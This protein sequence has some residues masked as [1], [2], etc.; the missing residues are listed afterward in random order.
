MTRPRADNRSVQGPRF[1]CPDLK[2]GAN[3]LRDEESRHATQV[4]RLRP[5]DALALFD[6][7]G[8]VGAATVAAPSAEPRRGKRAG[9]G[10]VVQVDQL[11]FVPLPKRSLALVVAGCKGPRL[12][13]M[14]EKCVELDVHRIVL[15]EF[16]RSVVRVSAAHLE[17]L[18]RAAIEA[19]KQCGR[20][21]LPELSAGMSVSA[22]ISGCRDHTLIVADP[23]ERAV[24]LATWLHAHPAA[25]QHLAAVVGPEG[26]LTPEETELL[27]EAGAHFVRLGPHI[28]RVETAAVSIAA[29]ATARANLY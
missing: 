24:P 25:N 27:R 20:A 9:S 7:R 15:A 2:P 19:C 26:G 18:R 21:H 29:N 12:G 10:L 8:H 17:K 14:I 22:A 16:E 3:I 11:M 1:F 5:G 23:D 13:W 6:G 28:L 4:L